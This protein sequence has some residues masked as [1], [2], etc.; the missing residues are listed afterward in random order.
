MRVLD[1]AG[2]DG[3]L[4]EA[5]LTRLVAV[6]DTNGDGR[7]DFLEFSRNI[8]SLVDR[9]RGSSHW[10]GDASSAPPS[11]SAAAV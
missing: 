2:G 9:V 5:A 7:I 6:L 3:M 1:N 4:S 11:Q 10:S 8:G